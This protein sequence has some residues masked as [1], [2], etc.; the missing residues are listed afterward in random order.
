MYLFFLRNDQCR[1]DISG[2]APPRFA[3]SEII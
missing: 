3:A 1:F 2:A